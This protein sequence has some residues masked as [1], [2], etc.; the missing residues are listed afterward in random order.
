ME[1]EEKKL[2]ST[3]TSCVI[4]QLKCFLL[5]S[6]QNDTFRGKSWE[7]NSEMCNNS[8]NVDG[9]SMK[10]YIGEWEKARIFYITQILLIFKN[11]FK[12]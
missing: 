12:N 2:V 7:F 6:L 8:W 9:N 4:L 5:I 1:Y 3:R 10:F 11:N